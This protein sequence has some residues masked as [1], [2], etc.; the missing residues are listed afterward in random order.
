[1]SVLPPT[2]AF[3]T[4]SSS[5]TNVVN[6]YWGE[7]RGTADPIK[8]SVVH[9]IMR[10]IMY[11][12]PN[13]TPKSIQQGWNAIPVEG[14]A[15]D[16]ETFSMQSKGAD[17]NVQWWDPETMSPA[18]R[19]RPAALGTMWYPEGA[20]RYTIGTWPTKPLEFFDK[21][22]AVQVVDPPPEMPVRC[23]GCPSE[24]GAGG[25]STG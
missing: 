19:D 5:T 21:A 15:A 2:P 23:P 10:S 16:N 14:G 17:F 4:G 18:Y 22:N 11:A 25:S 1:M 6:W 8:T 9:W 3:V 12:G 24:T 20:K 7:G 13:L